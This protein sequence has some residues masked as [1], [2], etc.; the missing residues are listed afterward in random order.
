MKKFITLLLCLLLT[1]I[2]LEAKRVVVTG[3]AGFLGSHLCERLLS[4]NC[5]VICVD[6]FGTGTPRNIEPFTNHP[7]FTFLKH[8]ICEPLVIEEPI[9]EIYNLACPASPKFYQ[10]DGID[11]LKT[12]FLGTLHLLELAREKGA[13][14]LQASTSEIYGDPLVH[15]QKE[16]YWGNVNSFGVRS[17]YDEGKRV[18]E[19]ICFEYH[20]MHQVAVKVVRIFNTYGPNM[21][22]DDGRVVSNFI[23]QALDGEPISIYGEGEQTR[24]FCYVSDLIDGFLAM[25]ESGDEFIGPVNLG[26]PNEITVLE[27]A[28]KILSLTDSKSVLEFKELPK[29]DPTKRKPD[30]TLAKQQLGWEPRIKLEDGLRKTIHYFE[31]F[32]KTNNKQ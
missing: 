2:Q 3:G 28:Q 6:H 7:R 12:N 14:I 19:A 10:Q 16:S 30:I 18:A 13:K 26:N 15:P 31:V 11:T 4:Q 1:T 5:D 20:Q 23:R 22:P 24:S 29:D 21:R 8:D 17:C 9:D 32:L 27:L 25:M